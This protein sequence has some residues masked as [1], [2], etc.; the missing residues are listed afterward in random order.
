MPLTST[1]GISPPVTAS[2][3]A[4]KGICSAET[5]EV[6]ALLDLWIRIPAKGEPSGIDQANQSVVYI[7]N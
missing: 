1:I 7:F 6:E 5:R 3:S 4:N 2:A